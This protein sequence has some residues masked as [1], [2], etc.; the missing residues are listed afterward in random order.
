MAKEFIKG[1]VKVGIIAEND[2]AG[3]TDTDNGITN[4]AGAD[5]E[6]EALYDSTNQTYALIANVESVSIDNWGIEQEEFEHLAD[7]FT[8]EIDIRDMGGCTITAIGNYQAYSV[9]STPAAGD[10]IP[11]NYLIFASMDYPNGF[12]NTTGDLSFN[13]ALDT[14][15]TKATDLR[16]YGVVIEREA[17]TAGKFLQWT[18]HNAKINLVPGIETKKGTR[19]TLSISDARYTGFS[20][21]G[22]TFGN[23]SDS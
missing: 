5:G 12:N 3:L 9:G 21:A 13:A 14:A 20:V 15:T 7:N 22:S 16:G 10:G 2:T 17:D 18:L 1:A 23:H 4:I 6:G 8:H 19:F 11:L